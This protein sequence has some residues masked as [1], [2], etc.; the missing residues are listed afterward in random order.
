M[1]TMEKPD[2]EGGD[3]G[4]RAPKARID[5]G[6]GVKAVSRY[7]RDEEGGGCERECGYGG[8]GAAAAADA[9][10]EHDQRQLCNMDPN[11]DSD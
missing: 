4:R 11:E 9:R 2:R 3:G 10:E 7:T 8:G 6:D 1:S 5:L